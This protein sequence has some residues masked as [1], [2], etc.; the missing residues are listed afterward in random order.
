MIANNAKETSVIEVPHSLNSPIILLKYALFWEINIYRENLRC[1]YNGPLITTP[2]QKAPT[3]MESTLSTSL[4][5]PRQ[6]R[7]LRL[8]SPR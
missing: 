4:L 6:C 5:N 8:D 2:N 7:R 1:L 3:H